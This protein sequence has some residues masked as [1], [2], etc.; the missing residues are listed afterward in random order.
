MKSFH[1]LGHVFII[2]EAGSNWK[3]GTYEQDLEQAKKLIKVAAESG[4]DAIKFQTYK[5]ETIY[6]ENAG[7]SNYLSENGINDNINE[8]FENLSMPYEMIPELKKYCDTQKIIFMSSPFSVQDAKEVDPFVD[9]HKV[10]SFEINHIRLLEFLARTKKPIIVS[11]GA[12]TYD[13]IDFVVELIKKNGNENISL[14]QCTS[15]Y[16]CPIEALNLNTIPEMKK[17]YKLSIGFS[18]HSIEPITGPVSAVL[19][20]AKIIE[21]HF[22]LDKNLPGPDHPFALNPKELKDMISAIRDAEKALGSG[23]KNM[24]SAIRDAEKA[25]GSGKKQI[26][27]EEQELRQFAT[28]SIQAIQDIK[29][30]DILQEGINFEIL[31]SGNKKRGIEPRF[32]MSVNGKKSKEDVPKGDGICHVE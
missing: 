20:G 30:G 8:I 24:I 17:R 10:A 29:K 27:A 22:T 11:T 2:A 3:C 4:A 25:L 18:D 28:R 5:P 23:K 21:K 19:L 16:P 31:R 15:K 7:V 13:E 6:V 12:S 9:I 32:L 1:D 14:L 26:L